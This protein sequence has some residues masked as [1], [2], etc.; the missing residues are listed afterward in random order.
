VRTVADLGWRA[1]LAGDATLRLGLNTWNGHVTNAAVASAHG[2]D[3]SPLAD[4]FA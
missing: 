4:V 3:Y 2:M 1:A